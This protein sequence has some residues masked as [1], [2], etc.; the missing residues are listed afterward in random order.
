MYNIE[1]T[2]F[3]LLSSLLVL[4]LDQNHEHQA[5]AGFS[6]QPTSSLLLPPPQEMMR[7]R[8]LL[9]MWSAFIPLVLL[10]KRLRKPRSGQDD[11]ISHPGYFIY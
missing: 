8:P 1:N 3:A 9:R 2:I 11:R 5:M 6:Y 7:Y 10:R 4:V